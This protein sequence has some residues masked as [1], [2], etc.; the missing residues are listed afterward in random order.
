MS[1][2]PHWF[3]RPAHSATLSP[4]RCLLSGGLLVALPLYE[5]T[6]VRFDPWRRQTDFHLNCRERGMRFGK[7]YP[8]AIDWQGRVPSPEAFPRAP[9]LGQTFR[10]ATLSL[11]SAT[12]VPSRS[13]LTNRLPTGART[14]P[15]S[16]TSLIGGAAIMIGI[17]SV[18]IASPLGILG[19]AVIL[20]VNAGVVRDASLTAQARSKSDRRTLIRVDAHTEPP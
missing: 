17:S 20:G 4:L 12:S 8:I 5:G 15:W 7:V 9:S 16:R 6:D 3:S 2:H 19:P 13:G 10:P 1:L 11:L 14:G 18:I